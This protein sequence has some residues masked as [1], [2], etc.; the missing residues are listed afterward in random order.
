VGVSGKKGV[1]ACILSG[2]MGLDR[3]LE[4]GDMVI[5]LLC[6]AKVKRESREKRE[7]SQP[8]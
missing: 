8:L 6:G 2:K 3:K 5:K 1:Q 7:R 4:G